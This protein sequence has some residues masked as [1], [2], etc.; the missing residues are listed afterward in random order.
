MSNVEVELGEDDDPSPIRAGK[1]LGLTLR[2]PTTGAPPQVPET[3]QVLL[4]DA[5]SYAYAVDREGEASITVLLK[6]SWAD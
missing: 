6:D 3:L 5:G 1:H 4:A 2:W